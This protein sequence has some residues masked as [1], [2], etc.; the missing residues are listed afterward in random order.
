MNE[1]TLKLSRLHIEVAILFGRRRPIQFGPT[2]PGLLNNMLAAARHW[3]QM[4]EA[5]KKHGYESESSPFHFTVMD[6]LKRINKLRV[7]AQRAEMRRRMEQNAKKAKITRRRKL[8]RPHVSR[9]VEHERRERIRSENSAAEEGASSPVLT[10][11]G[12]DR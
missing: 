4:E 3:E 1:P 11:S 8:F 6:L 2:I 7:E 9:R 12:D 10:G 5:R